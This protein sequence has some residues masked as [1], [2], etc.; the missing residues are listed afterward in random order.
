MN[1]TNNINDIYIEDYKTVLREI[2]KEL[3]IY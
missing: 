1:L 2:S 3:N